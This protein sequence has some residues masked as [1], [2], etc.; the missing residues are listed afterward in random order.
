MRTDLTYVIETEDD[1]HEV[2]VVV[3]FEEDAYGTVDG[4]IDSIVDRHDPKAEL[5]AEVIEAIKAK[6][7]FDDAQNQYDPNEW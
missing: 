1:A 5:P 4:Y 6:N 2:D 3:Y 7:W